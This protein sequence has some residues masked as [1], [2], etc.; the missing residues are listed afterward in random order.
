MSRGCREGAE[1]VWRW[2]RKSAERV[3]KECRDAPTPSDDVSVVSII[4]HSY[5]LLIINS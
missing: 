4:T 1:R 3:P 2:S 5:F